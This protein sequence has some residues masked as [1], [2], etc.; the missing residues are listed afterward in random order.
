MSNPEPENAHIREV[1]PGEAAAVVEVL[2]A[3]LA[4]DPFVQW[5]VRSKPRARRAYVRLMVEE[6]AVPRGLVEVAEQ[7]GEVCGAALW[8]PPRTFSLSAWDTIRLMPRM[9]SII[10]LGRMNETSAKLEEVEAA[11]PPEPYW[12]LTLLGIAPS[13]R[14]RGLGS[15]LMSRVLA[16]CDSESSVAACETASEANLAFYERHG[17]TVTSS[18]SLGPEGP[19]SW[20]LIREPSKAT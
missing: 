19:T 12:L 20:S 1:R 9:V 18:R 10:G 17:F 13:A 15:A 14:R 2:D 16:R 5:L 3:A 6:I 7:D 4:D 11:R 8:A